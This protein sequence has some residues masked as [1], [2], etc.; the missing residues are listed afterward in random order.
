MNQFRERFAASN[1]NIGLFN[2]L[3][4]KEASFTKFCKRSDVFYLV[5]N[6]MSQPE[7]IP[8]PHKKDAADV[9]AHVSFSCNTE[10][11]SL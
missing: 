8:F 1:A 6:E 7:L 9:L 10:Y 5:S 2:F 4:L 3:K 11:V